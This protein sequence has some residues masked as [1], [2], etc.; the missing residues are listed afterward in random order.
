MLHL[1]TGLMPF[2]LLYRRTPQLPSPLDFQ[3]PVVKYPVVETEYAKEL[4]K[5]FKQARSVAHKNIQGKQMEQNER[6]KIKEI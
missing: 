6:T 2:Y 5:E 3:Q 4:V 1:S